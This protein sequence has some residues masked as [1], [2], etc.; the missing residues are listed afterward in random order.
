MCVFFSDLSVGSPFRNQEPRNARHT[1]TFY[2]S[3]Q[4]QRP[5]KRADDTVGGF[6]SVAVPLF[7]FLC[8]LAS[9][10]CHALREKRTTLLPW[11]RNIHFSCLLVFLLFFFFTFFT[12]FFAKRGKF[13]FFYTR[14]T[15]DSD[16]KPT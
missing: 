1:K 11:R 9:N 6:G 10:L 4:N 16:T 12:F 14:R 15:K 13:C 8:R 5:H 3:L 2:G 7:F